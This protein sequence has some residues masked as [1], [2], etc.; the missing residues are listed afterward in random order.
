MKKLKCIN[1]P[2][3][4]QSINGIC[5]TMFGVYSIWCSKNKQCIYVGMA[6]PQSSIKK[7]LHDHW[8]GGHNDMLWLWIKAFG[9]HLEVCYIPMDSC[10]ASIRELEEQLISLW[11]PKT[12]IQHNLG[13]K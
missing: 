3:G 10:I 7:R 13:R 2:W 5:G 6:A 1:V 9:D 4:Y 8:K 12:N 11:N